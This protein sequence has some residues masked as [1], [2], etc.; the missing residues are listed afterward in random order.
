MNF[1]RSL[2]LAGIFCGL[3]DLAYAGG[4]LG[5]PPGGPIGGPIG[6]PH[7]PGGPLG[8]PGPEIGDGVVGFAVAAA[9]V[10][11]FLMLPRIKRMLQSKTI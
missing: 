8:A 7:P 10:L 5:G 4:P 6:P 3:T 1:F 9:V 2:T 11:G